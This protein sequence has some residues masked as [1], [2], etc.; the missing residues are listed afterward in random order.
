MKYFH[1]EV[2]VLQII[3]NK[4]QISIFVFIFSDINNRESTAN[5]CDRFN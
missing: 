5:I 3:K 1:V 2:E 4:R